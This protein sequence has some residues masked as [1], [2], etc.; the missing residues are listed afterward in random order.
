MG[1]NIFLEIISIWTLI[2]FTIHTF[3]LSTVQIT[4]VQ[5]SAAGGSALRLHCSSVL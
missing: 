5:H 3:W 1:S 2:L 4:A